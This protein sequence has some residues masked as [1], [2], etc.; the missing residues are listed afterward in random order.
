MNIG[1]HGTCHSLFTG[2]VNPLAACIEP[3]NQTLIRM[4]CKC[5]VRPD[6]KLAGGLD[7]TDSVCEKQS[8]DKA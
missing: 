3:N 5:N 7:F 6:Q 4:R 1:E 2:S 8:R